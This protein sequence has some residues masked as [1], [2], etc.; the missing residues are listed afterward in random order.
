MTRQIQEALAWLGV[1]W[2]EGPFLQSER[3]ARHR[4]LAERLLV[5]GRAYRCFCSPEE[6]EALRREAQAAKATFKYPRRCLRLGGAQ[7]E[8]RLA[9]GRPFVVRFK[10]PEGPIRFRDLVRGDVE[11]GEEAALDDFILLRSDGSPTYHL[12]VVADDLDMGVTHVIRGDD[13]LS[14]TPKHVPLFEALGGSVPIFA[15][16]PLILGRTRSACPSAPAPP[17]SR[18]FG[19]RASSLRRFTTTWRSSAGRRATTGR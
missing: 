19:R 17:R 11:F 8:A 16:L 14:N 7:A 9:E 2:D 4:E 3:L 12:S 6:L 13:H 10:L 5:E 1:E 18:S 15:H